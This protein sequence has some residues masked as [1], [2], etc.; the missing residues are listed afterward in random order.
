MRATK[1]PERTR[2]REKP[3]A[4]CIGLG[5]IGVDIKAGVISSE[6]NNQWITGS[7]EEFGTKL[8]E[9]DEARALFA[10]QS[11]N[12]P[13]CQGSFGEELRCAS[14]R[15]SVDF[16]LTNTNVWGFPLRSIRG[17]TCALVHV[18]TIYIPRRSRMN[19]NT[20]KYKQGVSRFNRHFNEPRYF[21]QDNTMKA[22]ILYE[23]DRARNVQ[24][25][26]KTLIL[27]WIFDSSSMRTNLSFATSDT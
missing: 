19:R 5:V 21:L 20:C 10:F 11:D 8:T 3:E 27:K 12:D 1:F 15:R 24:K 9:N 25:E 26:R 6:R 17:Y 14:R 4:P 7:T 23:P 16:A 13:I 18:Y 22:N 2:T